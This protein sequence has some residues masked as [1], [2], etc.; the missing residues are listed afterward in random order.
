VNISGGA[1]GMNLNEAQHL[2]KDSTPLCVFMLFFRGNI[3]LLV[4]ETN[5][6]YRQYLY[7]LE[8]GPS[9]LPDMINSETFQMGHDIRNRLRITGQLLSNFSRLSVAELCNVADF[10][11][12]FTSFKLQTTLQKLKDKPTIMTDYG[13][14]GLYMTLNEKRRSIHTKWEKCDVGLCLVRCFKESQTKMR[15]N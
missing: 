4:E 3:H 6:Y 14:L 13:K 5:R 7:S 11:T 1:V 12:S 9:H 8:D 15:F 10:F 2:N